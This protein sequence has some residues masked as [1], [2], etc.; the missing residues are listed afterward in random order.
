MDA[1]SPLVSII[2]PTY[3]RAYI[4]GRAIE[5]ILSQSFTDFELI[6]VDD[7]SSDNTE[8]VVNS[9]QDRR[10]KFLRQEKNRG[11]SVAINAGLRIASG[12]FIAIQ[13]SDDEWYPHKLE[14]EVNVLR[15]SPKT[16]GVVYSRIEKIMRDGQKIYLPQ[17]GFSPT[18][19]NLHKQ[20]L[21]SNFITPQAT[22]IRRECFE[23]VGFFD[24][25]PRM[26]S[27]EDW[28]LWIRFSMQFEFVYI[29]KVGART[30]ISSD[31]LT[32]DQER[33]L[34]AREA[35]FQKHHNHFLRYPDIYIKQSYSIGN[36]FA[37]RG[38][39]KRARSYLWTAFKKN[40]LNIR[41][42]IAFL[43]V[44]IGAPS[45]YRLVARMYVR[46]QKFN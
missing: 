39:M 38:E 29:G 6:I 36:A 10:I 22:L 3:N 2:L 17:D 35:I 26:V 7:G 16:V 21:S 44:W 19:G 33:R 42:A 45:L 46:V 18:S 28:E 11:V 43:V 12:V 37:L 4:V 5:S 15:Q 32:Q 27:L 13:G 23:S 8:Q 20:I 41:Y 9:F 24:E 30:A 25:D 31:S 1:S 34:L 40:P 14:Q